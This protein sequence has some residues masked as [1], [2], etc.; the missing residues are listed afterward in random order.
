MRLFLGL[1]TPLCFL[2]YSTYTNLGI[3]LFAGVIK[4]RST[5]GELFSKGERL[6]IGSGHGRKRAG[7]KDVKLNLNWWTGCRTQLT[8]VFSVVPG[9]LLGN[10]LATLNISHQATP[11][12]VLSISSCVA[13]PFCGSASPHPQASWL[14]FNWLLGGHRTIDPITLNCFLRWERLG[15]KV[16]ALVQVHP[17]LADE[18]HRAGVDQ[19]KGNKWYCRNWGCEVWHTIFLSH[20]S[21]PHAWLLYLGSPSLQSFCKVTNE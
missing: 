20:N 21:T 3:P 14:A 11:K 8:W 17:S 4:T 12:D 18:P 7:T 10:I 9:N 5:S 13:T 19:S 15:L 16:Q 6:Q 1:P 2:F